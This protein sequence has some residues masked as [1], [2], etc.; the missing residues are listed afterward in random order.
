[1]CVKDAE[2]LW[3]GQA[4]MSL[5]LSSEMKHADK[6]EDLNSSLPFNSPIW[7]RIYSRLLEG[8]EE[9]K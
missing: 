3:T 7:W 2:L 8:E 1:M 5:N 9:I 6:V 4:L